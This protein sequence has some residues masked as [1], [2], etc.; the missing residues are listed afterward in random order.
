MSAAFDQLTHVLVALL[1]A[2]MAYKESLLFSTLHS[3]TVELKRNP[4]Y[5]TQRGNPLI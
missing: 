3:L 4:T 2:T 5:L 1:L